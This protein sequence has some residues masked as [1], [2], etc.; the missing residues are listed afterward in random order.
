MVARLNASSGMPVHTLIISDKGVEQLVGLEVPDPSGASWRAEGRVVNNVEDLA[1]RR[2]L[3]I[4]SLSNTGRKLGKKAGENFTKKLSLRKIAKFLSGGL[5]G[6]ALLSMPMAA[7]AAE[8]GSAA[9]GGGSNIMP[10]IAAVAGTGIVLAGWKAWS[11]RVAKSEKKIGEFAEEALG[12][13]APRFRIPTGRDLIGGRASLIEN[14]LELTTRGLAGSMS[15]VINDW[16]YVRRQSTTG[17]VIDTKWGR[18]WNA[19]GTGKYAAPGIARNGGIEGWATV[20]SEKELYQAWDHYI[21]KSEG[22]G[23]STRRV[24]YRALGGKGSSVNK[25]LARWGGVGTLFPGAMSLYFA[26]KDAIHGYQKEGLI[27][28]IK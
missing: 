4:K 11:S 23:S 8:I 15:S 12:D 24:A 1:K 18:V 14:E 22:L 27:G 26:A 3:N 17:G 5:L 21:M 9:A 6:A 7:N 13:K 2:G 20:R 19:N 16:G 25:F 10:V 28:G